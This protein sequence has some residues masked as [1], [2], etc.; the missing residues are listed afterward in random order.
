MDSRERLARVLWPH[1]IQQAFGRNKVEAYPFGGGSLECCAEVIDA[2]LASD[3]LRDTLAAERLAGFIAGLG[4][5][6]DAA[7]Q[8]ADREADEHNGSTDDRLRE[9][10][11]GAGRAAGE[12][13]AMI[14]N[15]EPEASD[16]R[17]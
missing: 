11:A 7:K 4:L 17:G 8:V 6:E 9:N 13:A 15:L 2:I 5:A 16:D 10:R 1:L 12:I 3:W 14:R